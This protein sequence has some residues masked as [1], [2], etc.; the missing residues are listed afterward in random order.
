MFFECNYIQYYIHVVP[1]LF[2]KIFGDVFHETNFMLPCL[3]QAEHSRRGAVAVRLG[4]WNR[5]GPLGKMKELHRWNKLCRCC[6]K[7]VGAIS[8]I[9]SGHCL[10]VRSPCFF[11]LWSCFQFQDASKH[12]QK[13]RRQQVY[14]GVFLRCFSVVLAI[15]LRGLWCNLVRLPASTIFHH[16]VAG[17]AGGLCHSNQAGQRSW[18]HLVPCVRRD[19][20]PWQW[21]SSLMVIN[22]LTMVI[23]GY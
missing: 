7:R 19:G 17:S 2:M 1:L 15:S 6:D 5:L 21:S 14:R 23:D 22:I 10:H 20:R 12:C 3:T 13:I 9:M 11:T 18:W 16:V 8:N 4:T